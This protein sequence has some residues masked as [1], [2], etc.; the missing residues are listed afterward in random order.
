M[1]SL[2]TADV[3]QRNNVRLSGN[4]EGRVLVFAH[5]FGCS[6]ETWSL[7][8]PAFERDYRVVLFD[9]IG[10]GG[11]DRR[12]YSRGKYDSLDGYATDV[13]EILDA[14]DVSDVVF[15]GHSV[16][17]MVGVLAANRRPERFG[18]LILVGPSPR[19]TNEGDYRGGFERADIDSLLDSLDANFLAWSQGIAPM[20]MGRPDRPELGQRLA[21]TFCRFDPQIAREFARVTFLSDNRADLAAVSVPTLILQCRADAIAPREVGDF[22]HREIR[23]S[24]LRVLEATG[25]VPILSSPEEVISEIRLFLA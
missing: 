4:P 3:L 9:Y 17:A 7:V 2:A 24:R 18:A 22:V 23:G 11:A 5:G 25:H 21:D 12:A 14:L 16:S 10:A 15:I 20:I 8:A 13:L 1:T 6:Q 19:Y